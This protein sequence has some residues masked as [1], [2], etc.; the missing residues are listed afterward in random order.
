MSAISPPLDGKLVFEC[1]RMQWKAT[2]YENILEPSGPQG[3][4]SQRV[5]SELHR[6]LV[7]YEGLDEVPQVLH[8]LV[9]CEWEAHARIGGSVRRAI[10]K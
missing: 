8:D 4:Q 1:N 10:L 6:E 7:G 5:M 3:R 2:E 9:F